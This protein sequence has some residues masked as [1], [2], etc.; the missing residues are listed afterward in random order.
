MLKLG[1]YL[2]GLVSTSPPHSTPTN[3]GP[4]WNN[5]II[6][7]GPGT[8]FVSIPE[9]QP[10]IP[11]QAVWII[12]DKYILLWETK[13]FTVPGNPQ[14]LSSLNGVLTL[15]LCTSHIS[16]LYSI[17]LLQ[18]MSIYVTNK[19]LAVSSV[20]CWISCVWPFSWPGWESFIHQ[21]GEEEATDNS[22]LGILSQVYTIL[23][24]SFP[25]WFPS[26]PIDITVWVNLTN[27]SNVI[28]HWN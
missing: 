5:H 19:L 23:L 11:C 22:H 9:Y 15:L 18:A 25:Q 7:R 14:S 26:N 16:M 12:L 20:Q 13:Y 6:L 24:S 1:E 2:T 3:K 27:H 28:R 10:L 4:L 8:V 21:W 17:L